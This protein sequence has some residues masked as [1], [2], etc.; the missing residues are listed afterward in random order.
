MSQRSAPFRAVAKR[1]QFD[2]GQYR[3]QGRYGR[4]TG[5]SATRVKESERFEGRQRATVQQADMSNED[6]RFGSQMAV[7]I[8]PLRTSNNRRTGPPSA[9]FTQ[10]VE[11]LRANNTLTTFLSAGGPSTRK[12][13]SSP[14]C[15]RRSSMSINSISLWL[16]DAC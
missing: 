7:E 1:I 15:C 14:L 16:L 13:P 8:S 9:S 6:Q 12:P 11:E 5:H 2:P 10:I 3:C 4:C